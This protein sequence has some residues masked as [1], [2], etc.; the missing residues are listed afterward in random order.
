[1]SGKGAVCYAVRL[2]VNLMPRK[3]EPGGHRKR[4]V[5]AAMRETENQ[6]PK[7]EAREESKPGS[8]SAT[9]RAVVRVAEEPSFL[10]F[11]LACGHLVTVKKGDLRNKQPQEMEC[12]AC[13]TQQGQM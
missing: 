10:H 7:R 6:Q 12:W 11:Y 8:T 4:I 5:V 9:M 13:S 3:A 1:M 2:L